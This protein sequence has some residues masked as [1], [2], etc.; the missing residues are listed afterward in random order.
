MEKPSYRAAGLAGELLA[1]LESRPG[2]APELSLK[3]DPVPLTF[4]EELKDPN[5]KKDKVLTI[6]VSGSIYYWSQYLGE[7][8]VKKNILEITTGV[9][10][11]VRRVMNLFESFA[12]RTFCS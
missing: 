2:N 6:V 9:D 5:R 1:R 4:G 3:V 10:K 11:E 12:F 7:P 8:W